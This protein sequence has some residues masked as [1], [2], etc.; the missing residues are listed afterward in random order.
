MSVANVP[1]ALESLIDSGELTELAVGGDDRVRDANVWRIT[2]ET[3]IDVTLVEPALPDD[4]LVLLH[5][6]LELGERR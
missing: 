4:V 6:I 2:V 3:R 5:R 1:A